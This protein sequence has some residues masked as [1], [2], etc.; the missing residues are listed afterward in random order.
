MHQL[1]YEIENQVYANM[2]YSAISESRLMNSRQP[3]W[4]FE[5][6]QAYLY[7]YRPLKTR[8]KYEL[9]IEKGNNL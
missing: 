6:W 9:I 3:S 4:T 7:T 1:I 2:D 5:Q 8:D